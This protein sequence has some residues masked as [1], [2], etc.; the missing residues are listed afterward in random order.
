M[1]Q[2]RIKN[3]DLFVAHW[4][5]PIPNPVQKKTQK[6]IL[7]HDACFPLFYRHFNKQF[8]LVQENVAASI[9]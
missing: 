2:V 7:S 5:I 8:K 1:D 6:P 4:N 3:S 9:T